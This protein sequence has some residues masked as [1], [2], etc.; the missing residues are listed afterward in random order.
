MVEAWATLHAV[1]FI[2]EIWMFNIIFE[3][4]AMQVVKEINSDN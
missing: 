1:I 4:D 2:K 3:G